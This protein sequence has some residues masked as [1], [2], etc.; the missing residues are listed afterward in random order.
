MAYPLCL[1]RAFPLGTAWF[2]GLAPVSA[3][4]RPRSFWLFLLSAKTYLSPTHTIGG[5]NLNEDLDSRQWLVK[6]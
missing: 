1:D 6:V 4:A 2:R 3:V 5:N